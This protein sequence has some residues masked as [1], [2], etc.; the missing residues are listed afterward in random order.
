MW[1]ISKLIIGDKGLIC[2]MLD[3]YDLLSNSEG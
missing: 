2:C 1:L 3:G